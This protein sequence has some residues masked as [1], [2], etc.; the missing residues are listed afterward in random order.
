MNKRQ[1]HRRG[2]TL[3]EMVTTMGCLFALSVAASRLLGSI[4]EI[5]LSR[6]DTFQESVAVRRFADSFR[7]D[8]ADAVEVT[9]Q[10][11]PG[12][13]EMRCDGGIVH[14]WWD[15]ASKRLF[16]VVR[17]DSSQDASSTVMET[18]MYP[19]TDRCHPRFVVTPDRVSA[20]LREV[21]ASPGWIVEVPR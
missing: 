5:G 19:L 21:G 16:R 12:R 10:D 9:T 4:T 6:R 8:V 20:I 14:Y 13:L 2:F 3:L 1:A 7:S 11:E 17:S 18:D 15:P